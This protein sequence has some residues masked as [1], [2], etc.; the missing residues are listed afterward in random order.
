MNPVTKQTSEINDVLTFT[1][2]GVNVSLAN[3]L[4]RT[5]IS[6]I[7]TIVFKTIPHEENKV[8]IIT[9]TSRLNNEILKQRLSCIPI[10][11]T[12]ME[13]TLK[14]YVVELNVENM[15]DTMM[16]VTTGDFKIK[17]INTNDYLSEK[18]TRK[19]F[20]FN[21]RTGY[22]ID[23]VRLRPKVSDEIKGEKIHLISEFSI[24][25]PKENSMYNVVSTCSYGYT[26]DDARVEEILK[27]K[28]QEWKDKE[29]TKDEIEFESKNWK[30]LE[31]QRVVIENSFDFV[32]QSV[33][34]YTNKEL[35]QKAS[36][37]LVKKFEDLDTIID[38][39]E[40]EIKAS[41]NTL[42]NCYDI[43]L[44]NDDYTIGK[45][46]EYGLYSKYFEGLKTLAFCGFKK[47]HPHDSESI[48]RV[49]YKEDT[50]KSTIKQNLKMCIVDLKRVFENIN[51]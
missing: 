36:S 37:I 47:M 38:K 28:Q 9:N 3:A 20:P 18:D 23:F 4:R 40:L 46:I 44:E 12:D 31:G 50:D 27:K 15:T 30:L 6:D 32:I 26:I 24:S 39:D 33:G 48:I 13:T 8:S 29:F 10:H 43:I 45:S 11:I 21:D 41:E 5:I 51:I 1:L 2:S 16:Y 25:T 7:P 17:N 14:D 22:F 34:I 35:V 49:A 42:K 19:I